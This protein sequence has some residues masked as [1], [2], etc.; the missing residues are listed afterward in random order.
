MQV[1]SSVMQ[2]VG[3]LARSSIYGANSTFDTQ[4]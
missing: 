1:R 2:M 3:C 4:Q